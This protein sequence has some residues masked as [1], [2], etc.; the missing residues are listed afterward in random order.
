LDS[1][2]VLSYASLADSITIKNTPLHHADFTYVHAKTVTL[3]NLTISDSNLAHSKFD[4]LTLKNVKLSGVL[5]FTD[6]QSKSVLTESLTR[7]IGLNLVT[8]KASK[9]EL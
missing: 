8:D 7:D 1:G 5:D 2:R 4:K 9:I 6:T 3:E